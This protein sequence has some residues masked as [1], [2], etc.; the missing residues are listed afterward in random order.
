VATSPARPDEPG[1]STISPAVHLRA[2]FSQAAYDAHRIAIAEQ[3]VVALDS[4][5]IITIQEAEKQ[6]VCVPVYDEVSEPGQ[7]DHGLRPLPP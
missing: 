1:G 6:D 3:I 7:L 5:D 4:P 2:A